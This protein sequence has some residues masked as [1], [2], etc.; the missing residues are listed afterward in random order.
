MFESEVIFCLS[1]D[2]NR[3]KMSLGFEFQILFIPFAFTRQSE[4]F[5]K[6]IRPKKNATEAETENDEW[7]K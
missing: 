4:H 7:T 6:S 1:L 5:F 2:Q 3:M